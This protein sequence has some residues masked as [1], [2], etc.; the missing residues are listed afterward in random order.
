MSALLGR[1]ELGDLLGAG[2]AARVV[3]ARDRTLGVSRAVK[4]IAGQPGPSRD[5]L[6]TRLQRE[7]RAMAQ[8]DHPN[9]LRVYDVGHDDGQD[10][11]VMDLADGGSLA[12]WLKVRGPMDPTVA[13]PFV[14]QV[15]AALAAA[16]AAGIVHRDVKPQNI[17]LD[18]N[19]KALLADFG[20]AMLDDDQRTTKTGMAMGSVAY[21]APEQRLD[22]RSVGRAAD[23][24]ATGATLYHLLTRANPVDLF[25]ADLSS[26]RFGGLP[27]GLR[28]IV[29]RATR[30]DPAQR[31][32]QAR[33]MAR[34]LLAV[35]SDEAALAALD[36]TLFPE[37]AQEMSGREPTMGTLPPGPSAEA[38]Q[39]AITFLGDDFELFRERLAHGDLRGAGVTEMPGGDTLVPDTDPLPA[40]PE[41]RSRP[42]WLLVPLAIAAAL[43]ALMLWPAP[44]VEPAPITPTVLDEPVYAPGVAAERVDAVASDTPTARP[45]PFGAW[46][47]TMN[48]R[49][50]DLAVRGTAATTSATWTSNIG[51]GAAT[52]LSGSY[53]GGVLTL[54][55]D[56]G[57]TFTLTFDGD[58]FTGRLSGVRSADV[59]NGRRP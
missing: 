27:A 57:D 24:Y 48:G 12:D 22:A 23:I 38:T 47:F 11:V 49:S 53:Q 15:L 46:R 29:F 20:I 52:A 51:A 50:H 34:D 14:V 10:F 9:V 39:G 13:I 42:T 21:M 31:Y 43:T 45:A 40:L 58:S 16:H 44:Y 33:E 32:D 59:L 26:A 41:P 17:L 5:A 2:G 56:D 1:Y 54:R 4:L 28:E 7:A 30:L 19:G 37:P 6:R 25:T 3:L 18:R 55:S 8:L 35:L 36:P